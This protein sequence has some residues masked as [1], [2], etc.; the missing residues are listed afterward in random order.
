MSGFWAERY[1]NPMF[2]FPI[3]D[4]HDAFAW[5]PITTFDGR[6]VWLRRVKRRRYHRHDYLSGGPDQWSIYATV[7]Q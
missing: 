7:K 2:G 1:A 4:W 6:R 5:L 3:T